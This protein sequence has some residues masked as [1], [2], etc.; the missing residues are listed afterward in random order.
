MSTMHIV[1]EQ[2]EKL[3][4]QASR[5]QG[6]SLERRWRGDHLSAGGAGGAQSAYRAGAGAGG[7]TQL[8]Q[9]SQLESRDGQAAYGLDLQAVCV[10]HG[11]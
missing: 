6:E 4:A 7:R 10:C 3:H 1:D 11:V 8:W 9:L 5:A 2:V